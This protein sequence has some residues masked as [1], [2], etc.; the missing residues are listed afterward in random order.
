MLAWDGQFAV[1]VRHVASECHHEA[2]PETPNVGDRDIL[3]RG[4]PSR[5]L[6]ED[7]SY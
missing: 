4:H 3:G 2:P 6:R 1:R 5:R 7:L